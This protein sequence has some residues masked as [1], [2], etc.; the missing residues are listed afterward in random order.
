MLDDGTRGMG[1]VGLTE[2]FGGGASLENARCCGGG[3][4][5][6]CGAALACVVR[7]IAV[8]VGDGGLQAAERARWDHGNDA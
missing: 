8:G 6:L 1:W 7:D 2:S 3:D 5:S 4:A